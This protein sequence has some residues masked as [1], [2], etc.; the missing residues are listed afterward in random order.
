MSNIILKHDGSV[1][2]ATGKSRKE[3]NWKNRDTDWSA[4]VNKVSTTHR[5][6]ETYAEYMRE[7]KPRQ[8]E[9]KDVGGF[10]GGY[11]ANGKRKNGNIMSRQLLTLDIDFGHPDF[12]EDYT[13]LYDNAACVY[14]THKHSPASPRLRFIAPLDREVTTDEYVVIARRIAGNLNINIFDDTTFQPTR[15]MYWPSTSKDGEYYF[16]YQDGPWLSADAILATYH[17]WRDASEWPVSDRVNDV[18]HHE[19]KK[20]EDPT[21]K[22][23]IIGAFCRTYN[24]HE[25]ID[26][27]LPGVYEA[28]DVEDR[29]TFIGG[30]TSAGLVVYDDK[31][32]YSHHGT[33]P[34]SGKLCNAFDLVRYHLYG[35]Q[36]EDCH[37]NTPSNKRP[38]YAAMV[39]MVSKD[40]GTRKRIGVEKLQEAMSEF[41]DLGIVM[42]SV[43][44]EETPVDSTDWLE[45][46]DVDGKGNYKSSIENARVILDNDPLLRGKFAFNEFERREVALGNL[47]WRKVTHET[48]YLTDNDDAGVRYYLEMAYGVSAPGKIK[49]ALDLSVHANS[50]H[51]VKE[52][53]ERVAGSWDVVGR[54]DTLLVDYLGAKDS[55]YVREVTRKTF[56]AAVARIFEPGIKFDYTLVLV[57]PQG[58][59][60]STLIR[61]MGKRWYSDSFS[62]VQG[63]EAFEQIQGVWLVEMGELA[64]L[65][66]AEINAIKHFISKQEDRYRVAYGRRTENFPRQS[67][68]IGT[69]NDTEFLNDPTGNRRFWPVDVAEEHSD[70]EVFEA[71]REDTVD[72]L[73]AEAVLAYRGGET[74][75]LNK[76][77]E[78]L[79]QEHQ[80]LHSELDDRVGLIF[81]YLNTPITDDWNTKEI[82]ERRNFY[83][84]KDLRPEGTIM[85]EYVSVAEIW[86]E[87]FGKDKAEMTRFNTR[88]IRNILQNLP[89][90][91]VEKTL[92]RLK[93][94]GPQRLYKRIK[95]LNYGIIENDKVSIEDLI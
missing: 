50:F 67:I 62:T 87:L 2:I 88:E 75:F 4:F 44:G 42:D 55:K 1:S 25:A 20:Q 60:K 66:K 80:K 5:T 15:L 71:M 61:K 43:E 84:D 39:E 27:F 57:G 93:F 7:K 46:L 38:S 78:A 83:M 81:E 95:C 36:D 58:C 91:Q 52:Y 26:T 48:R 16:Q 9:I 12:W 11:V 28:C 6:A 70:K 49:D 37:A 63:K 77:S 92:T 3:L 10:V 33:D 82:Y 73:W 14:S 24:I 13:M 56:V 23:G 89:E 21:E 65:K 34:I 45:K 85:R 18:I 17:N 72:Q 41:K 8:D 64:G 94:Y 35:L 40:P 32:A 47:P 53:L 22:P 79:A 51:P 54:L 59:G 19:M 30:S 68:F 29:Y 90:W 74:L 76:P 69:T 86:C 31:F